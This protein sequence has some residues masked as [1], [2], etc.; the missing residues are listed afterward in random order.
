MNR[1]TETIRIRKARSASQTGTGRAGGHKTRLLVYAVFLELT[2][3]G[4]ILLALGLTIEAL[5]PNL[6]F[7]QFLCSIALSLLA[8][9]I[10]ATAIL[11][12]SVR[13]PFPFIPKR[14]DPLSWIGIVWIAF[15]ITMF[16]ARIS[17]LLAPPVVGVFF[18][19]AYHFFRKVRDISK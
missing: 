13:A 10:A 3:I 14:S 11:G 16:S 2:E 8:A 19:L 15:L 1:D 6:I 4:L 18:F 17:P 9:L 12:R 7:S 5:V